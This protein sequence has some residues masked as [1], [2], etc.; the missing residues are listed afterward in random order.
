FTG[1]LSWQQEVFN[2]TVQYGYNA[3][4][5]QVQRRDNALIRL[6]LLVLCPVCPI[7]FERFGTAEKA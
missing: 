7:D 1:G 2:A 4:M 3:G 5:K 6:S